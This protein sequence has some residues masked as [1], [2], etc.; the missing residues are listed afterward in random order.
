MFF[1][2]CQFDKFPRT[3]TVAVKPLLPNVFLCVFL[4][5]F[6]FLYCKDFL[7]AVNIMS[8]TRVFVLLILVW[9]FSNFIF[10]NSSIL[11]WSSVL[12]KYIFEINIGFLFKQKTIRKF[13]SIIFI[14]EI[15]F[16]AYFH[17]IF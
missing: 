12:S 17:F 16:I 13:I 2:Y 5:C 4:L 3:F 9:L 7:A 15:A 10:L 6:V 8:D 14:C 11:C 1:L